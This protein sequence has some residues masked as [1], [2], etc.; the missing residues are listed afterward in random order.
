MTI[1]RSEVEGKLVLHVAGRMDAESAAQ[2]EAQCDACIA[3]GTASLVIDLGDLSYV[4]SMG[5]RSFVAVGQRLKGKGGELRICRLTGF[6]R[7]IFEIT[8]LNQVF[9]IYD[10]V[11]SAVLGG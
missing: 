11:E 3:E 5:L 9:P 8:R 4:S 7:Q 10:S 2:F 6:T 1:D